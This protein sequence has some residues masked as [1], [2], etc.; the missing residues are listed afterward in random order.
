MSFV[1]RTLFIIM[2]WQELHTRKCDVIKKSHLAL[3]L[4]LFLSLLSPFTNR[5]YKVSLLIEFNDF[6]FTTCRISYSGLTSR[7]T[8]SK[9]MSRV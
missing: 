9:K 7:Y 1:E 3:S 2:K 8:S 6:S 5:G 4:S